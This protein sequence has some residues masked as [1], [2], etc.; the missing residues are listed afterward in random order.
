MEHGLQSGGVAKTKCTRNNHWL[1]ITGMTLHLA[2]SPVHVGGVAAAKGW[3]SLRKPNRQR[4]VSEKRQ[5]AG[6]AEEPAADVRDVSGP[7]PVKA[8]GQVE[9]WSDG[10]GAR[11]VGEGRKEGE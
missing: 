9:R 2:P 7:R 6:R 5:E 11:K 1:N 4:R 8:D 10:R 3:E